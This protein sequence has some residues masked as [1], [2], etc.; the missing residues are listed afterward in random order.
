MLHSPRTLNRIRPPQVHV[1]RHH[2]GLA[3]IF[4]GRYFYFTTFY[5]KQNPG[6]RICRPDPIVTLSLALPHRGEKT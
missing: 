5:L 3:A 2:T 6:S 4:S 1:H